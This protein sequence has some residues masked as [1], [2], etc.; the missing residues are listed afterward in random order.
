MPNQ[1]R[2]PAVW[3]SMTRFVLTCSTIVAAFAARAASDGIRVTPQP[4]DLFDEIY[5][6]GRPL[7]SSLRTLTASF[8][9]T[10][11]SALLSTP[12]VARGTL[13]VE[14]PSRMVLQYRE[15]DARRVLIDSDV[16]LVSWPSK[17]IR[18]QQDIG[19][20]MDRVRKYFVGKSPDELRRH[21]RITAREAPDRPVGWHVDM[22]PTRK[23]IR[24]GV[25]RIELWISR[26]TILPTAMRLTFPGGNTKLMEFRDVRVNP[27]LPN[28]IFD[29]GALSNQD[30]LAGAVAAT[31]S[32]ASDS[33]GGTRSYSA[34]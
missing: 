31:R 12:L 10:S 18:R 11:T 17:S 22:V 6:R 24:Q 32:A 3:L 27:V 33:V 8:V 20:A 23:Q 28:A 13:A 14:R 30:H 25:S 5:E 15:P 29:R 21:F 26:E 4:R 19:A 16:L 34:R 7:E 1:R 9:E 2:D